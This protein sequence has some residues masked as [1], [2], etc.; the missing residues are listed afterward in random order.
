MDVLSS[1]QQSLDPYGGGYGRYF[2]GNNNTQLSWLGGAV[3]VKEKYNS[4]SGLNPNDQNT[5][6][7]LQLDYNWFRFNTTELQ[8][9]LQVYPRLSDTGR[10]RTNL[11]TSYSVNFTHDLAFRVVILTHIE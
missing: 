6:G 9:N 10:V 2:I 1:N 11:N 8:A 3:Y 7:L 4:H 5:E